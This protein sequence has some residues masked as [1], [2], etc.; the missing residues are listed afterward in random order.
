MPQ[1]RA[2]SINKP[3]FFG[4]DFIVFTLLVLNLALIRIVLN[5][6][7]NNKRNM[8][9]PNEKIK[10]V[11]LTKYNPEWA[12]IFTV[13]ANEIKSILKENCIQ[14]HHIGS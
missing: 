12:N 2:I 11:E 1:T 14:I 6:Q 9:D 5:T 10:L 13:A 7:L 4:L 8:I 3:S